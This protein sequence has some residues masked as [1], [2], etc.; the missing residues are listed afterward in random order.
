MKIA[1]EGLIESAIAV[2]NMKSKAKESFIVP[3]L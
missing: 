1:N 2:F 3:F